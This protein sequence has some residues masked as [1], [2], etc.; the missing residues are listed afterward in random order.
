[1]PQGDSCRGLFQALP[2][3]RYV[4]P[5]S[6]LPSLASLLVSFSRPNPPLPPLFLPVP[7]SSLLRARLA[8][9]PFFYV[10]GTLGFSSRTASD[11][12]DR[13]SHT[14]PEASTNSVRSSILIPLGQWSSSRHF[15]IDWEIYIYIFQMYENY[16]RD[17]KWI[18]DKQTINRQ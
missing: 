10:Y 4:R 11:Q 6:F 17:K 18:L 14:A 9:S 8:S 5:S 2:C 1:M 13:R 3:N 15:A 12:D 7:P 16:F